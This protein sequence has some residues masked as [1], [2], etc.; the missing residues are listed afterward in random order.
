MQ[1]L[2]LEP[3]EI[4]A[5]P[6]ELRERFPEVIEDLRTGVIEEV[7]EA[8]LNQLP[9]S[10]IDRI[11]EGL[12]ASNVNMTFVVILAAIAAIA[13]MGFFYG[14]AKDAGLA[15]WDENTGRK[16]SVKPAS[17]AASSQD[18]AD[19]NNGNSTE[20]GIE[21]QDGDETKSDDENQDGGGAGSSV[22]Q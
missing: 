8:V 21:K 18:G 2:Q 11:P 5:L 14:M 17:S 3:A 20:D 22:D 19:S 6:E 10:V 12:L 13:A 15:E 16:N 4:E 9:A 1:I 7:P